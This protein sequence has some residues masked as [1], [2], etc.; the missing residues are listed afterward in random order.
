MHHLLD[1][2]RVEVLVNGKVS[3]T[4]LVHR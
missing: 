2:D 3:G 1:E 4:T